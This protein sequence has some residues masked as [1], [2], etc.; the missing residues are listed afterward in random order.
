MVALNEVSAFVSGGSILPL[1][2][3]V[4]DLESRLTI[5]VYEDGT[6]Q[7]FAFVLHDGDDTVFTYDPRK[8]RISWEGQGNY[9]ELAFQRFTPKQSK[10]KTLVTRFTAQGYCDFDGNGCEHLDGVK[11]REQGSAAYIL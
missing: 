5:R 10:A 3:T 6:D 4:E 11:A 7:H 9:T 8:S 2:P 1:G